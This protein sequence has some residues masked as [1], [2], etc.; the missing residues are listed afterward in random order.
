MGGNFSEPI[1]NLG[2]GYLC[3]VFRSHDKFRVLH[4][5][6]QIHQMVVSLVRE[7]TGD[8]NVDVLTE[9][10]HGSVQFRLP[11]SPF[12]PTCGKE[13]AILGK[14]FV[15]KLLE[16]LYIKGYDFLNSAD[17]SRAYDQGTLFFKQG[18]MSGER[19]PRSIIA[20]APCGDDK[21]H[22]VNSTDGVV[23]TV[24]TAIT[25]AWKPGLKTD[26]ENE[27][28]HQLKLRGRP[29]AS[30]S[31]DEA[32]MARKALVAMVGH[33]AL[34]NWKF[35]AAVNIRNGCGNCLFF[36]H[37]ERYAM[38][39]QDFGIIAPGRWDRLRLVGFDQSSYEAAR[40]TVLRFH[41]NDPDDRYG[42][43]VAEYKLKGYPF[44]CA[45]DEAISARQLICRLLE[46][47]RDR[48]WQLLGGLDLGGKRSF[49]K[50]IFLM[51][52]CES[53]RLKFACVAPA[54]M[55]KLYLIN[56]PHQ[57]SQLLK[58]T[59]TKYYLPGLVSETARDASSIH[60]IV[61]QGPPWS[62]NTSYNL[63]ARTMLLMVIKDLSQYGWKLLACADATSKYVHHD[64]G[65]DYPIDVQSLYFC[66][67]GVPKGVSVPNSASVSFA[68][69]RVSDLE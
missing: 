68:E 22:L 41:Q 58:Q 46:A 16:N 4:G 42:S 14:M 40:M 67:N 47:L 66:F 57:I 33:L 36:M 48:G 3:F 25:S 65:V 19:S 5:N 32:I 38:T 54:D 63:H 29:W 10:K 59:V 64:N 49:E 20:I 55:D 62:Q 23:Q 52:R 44:S 21:L 15:L 13:S 34:S 37:D 43:G 53:A 11:G 12:S 69:L 1:V 28:Y 26:T 61:L 2:E 17:L 8:E 31:P 24:V 51:E 50:S 18:L 27:N 9:A 45:A 56:F 6:A 60:E 39:S 30:E 35:H 7:V